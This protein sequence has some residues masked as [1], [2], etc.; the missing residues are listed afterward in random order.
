MSDLDDYLGLIQAP[1]ALRTRI[2]ELL[3]AYGR[4]VDLAS[5][6]VFVSDVIDDEGNRSFPSMW[7]F[8]DHGA[9]EAEL[10][11]VDGNELDGTSISGRVLRWVSRTRDFSF[12]DAVDSS[13][14]ACG[15]VVPWRG[16]R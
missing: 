15:G 12:A 13:R 9:Y 16:R 7:V 5:A 11:S 6:E 14:S 8:T 1:D 4:I 3:E 2:Q 10:S